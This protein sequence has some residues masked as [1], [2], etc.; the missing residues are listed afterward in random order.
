MATMS[1]TNKFG[2][3]FTK[4]KNAPVRRSVTSPALSFALK[5]EMITQEEYSQCLMGNMEVSQGLL[6]NLNAD[7]PSIRT[8]T[9]VTLFVGRSRQIQI[10]QLLGLPPPEEII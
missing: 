6:H 3:A 4:K 1:R 7:H 10:N 8:G 2:G 5:G 9:S